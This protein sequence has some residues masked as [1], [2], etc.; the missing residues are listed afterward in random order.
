MIK[1]MFPIIE[2][3]GFEVEVHLGQDQLPPSENEEEEGD[4][5]PQENIDDEAKKKTYNKC[6]YSRSINP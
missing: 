5:P 6:Y 1:K 2:E 4:T 3:Y